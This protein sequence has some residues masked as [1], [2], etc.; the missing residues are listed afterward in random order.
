M[1]GKKSS[2]FLSFDYEQCKSLGNRLFVHMASLCNMPEAVS[3][4]AK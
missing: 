2:K 1:H 4:I 3:N